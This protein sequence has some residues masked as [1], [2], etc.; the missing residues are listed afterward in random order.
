E[1]LFAYLYGSTARGEADKKS[2]VDIGI[3]VRGDFEVKAF[4]EIVEACIGIA[5]HIISAKR[6]ERIKNASNL[7]F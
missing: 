7:S 3:F 2:D 6:F 4:Y 1:I 5:N